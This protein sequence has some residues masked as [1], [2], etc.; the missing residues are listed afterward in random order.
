M[1]GLLRWTQGEGHTAFVVAAPPMAE[2]LLDAKRAALKDSLAQVCRDFAAPI[3]D[4]PG[5]VADWSAWHAEAAAGDGAHPN[6]E[7]YRRV[8]EAFGRWAEWREWI[9]KD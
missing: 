6:A 2:P 7:G 3:L 1:A 4:L 9:E 5:A 8:A